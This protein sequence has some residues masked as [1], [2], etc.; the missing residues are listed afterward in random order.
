MNWYNQNQNSALKP[1][2]EIT[3]ITNLDRFQRVCTY[4][5]RLSFSVT[6]NPLIFSFTYYSQYVKKGIGKI[7]NKGLFN[8]RIYCNFF[9]PAG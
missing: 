6:N 1:K 5:G 9:D 2:W 7:V 4:T 3:K 8:D